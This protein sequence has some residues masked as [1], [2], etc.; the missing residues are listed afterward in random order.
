MA[1][2]AQIFEI[3]YDE[4]QKSRVRL[5]APGACGYFACLTIGGVNAEAWRFLSRDEAIQLRDHLSS[6]L[7]EELEKAA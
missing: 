7:S 1:T 2:D 5:R 6:L 4:I 3:D